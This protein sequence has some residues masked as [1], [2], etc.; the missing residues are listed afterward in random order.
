MKPADQAQTLGSGTCQLH[1]RKG[2]SSQ[3]L[4]SPIVEKWFRT[5]ISQRLAR[6]LDRYVQNG[7]SQHNVRLWTKLTLRRKPFVL[8]TTETQVDRIPTHQLE[9]PR[10]G[11]LIVRHTTDGGGTG[12]IRT[13]LIPMNR[14]G[15]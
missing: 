4:V 3:I 5:L 10:D 11:E 8:T 1:S 14:R 15:W 9:V 6:G 12:G 13:T 7:E 2:H